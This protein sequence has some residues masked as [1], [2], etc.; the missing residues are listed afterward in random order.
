VVFNVKKLSNDG[1]APDSMATGWKEA[2][3]A[4]W[5]AA[6]GFRQPKVGFASEHIN[7]VVYQELLRQHVFSWAQRMYPNVKYAFW[8]IQCHP[9]LPKPPSGCKQN[10]GLWWIGHRVCQIEL[11]PSIATEWDRLEAE[12][13]QKT[14]RSFCCCLSAVAK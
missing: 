5:A 13:I 14:C 12:Y 3:G 4:E 8:R 2:M 11:G 7:A 6:C 1:M 10:T 9:T